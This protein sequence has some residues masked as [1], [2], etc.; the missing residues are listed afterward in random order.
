[1]EQ[2]H[3]ASIDRAAE[4]TNAVRKEM[5][6]KVHQ[7]VSQA[8]AEV[9][10]LNKKISM[11]KQEAAEKDVELRL[12]K[13]RVQTLSE[14]LEEAQSMATGFESTTAQN[15]EILAKLEDQKMDVIQRAQQQED[16]VRE[17]FKDAISSS[18]ETHMGQITER[19]DSHNEK[20][21]RQLDK[22][23]EENG[24]LS[25]MV[26]S[27]EQR[28]A[29][30]EADLEALKKDLEAQDGH[31]VELEDKLFAMDTVQQ[32][33]DEI[34]SQIAAADRE[35]E[36]LTEQLESKA[37]AVKE[38]QNSL[39]CKDE[40]FMSEIREFTSNLVKLNQIVQEKEMAS[41]VLAEQAADT[42][43]REARIEAER[44]LSE[45]RT[46]L[47]KRLA[48]IA[49]EKDTMTERA[50]HRVNE[51]ETRVTQ[52][53][54]AIAT[55]EK[56]LEAAGSEKEAMMAEIKRHAQTI[57]ELEETLAVARSEKEVAVGEMKR[58]M[59]E[60][61]QHQGQAAEATRALEAQLA[62]AKKTAAEL[63]ET[64]AVRQNPR[65][66]IIPNSQELPVEDYHEEDAQE[67]MDYD[68]EHSRHFQN[69]R[70]SSQPDLL[71]TPNKMQGVLTQQRDEVLS[72]TPAMGDRVQSSLASQQRRVSVKSPANDQAIPTP[73]SVVDEKRNRRQ[74]LQPK[75]IIKPASQTPLTGRS[76]SPRSVTEDSTTP[77]TRQ[78]R[79]GIGKEPTNVNIN[80]ETGQAGNA[81]M[82][83]QALVATSSRRK[84]QGQSQSKS[85]SQRKSQSQSKTK[86]ESSAGGDRGLPN[87]PQMKVELSSQPKVTRQPSLRT[88]GSQRT[89]DTQQTARNSQG[90]LAHSQDAGFLSDR[91]TPIFP[92]LRKRRLVQSQSQ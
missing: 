66:V 18:V 17:S 9:E 77:A 41:K 19:L 47:E 88:Y 83:R 85:Q 63:Q 81:P 56:R 31:V 39:R 69:N 78:T 15:G 46:A 1:M 86:A 92:N 20:L 26:E 29:A 59:S 36:R 25:A 75:S 32:R 89:D 11:A 27:G 28:C 16:Q 61:R 24:R 8:G 58:C 76:E 50:N 37:T 3:K 34:Q 12:E 21:Q 82:D 54:Q 48:A 51:L 79:S 65:S 72:R 90:A 7:V 4:E 5:L 67:T 62:A 52:D 49:T 70:R 22:K 35:K 87:T 64:A 91:F 74:G 84:S 80:A 53:T 43:R 71:A 38:L 10:E 60:Y 6:Q 2:E 33:N 73:P 40:A 14:K 55:L 42:A 45:T 68:T 23:A 13:Q 44:A 57:S 30:L